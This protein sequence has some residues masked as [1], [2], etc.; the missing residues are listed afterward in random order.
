MRFSILINESISS[1]FSSSRGF[2]QGDPLSPLLFVIVMDALSRMMSTTVYNVLLSGFSIG[3]RNDEETIVL[4]LLI[5]DDT[6]IFCKPNCE[7]LCTCNV[8]S[9]FLISKIY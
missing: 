6:L 2:R 1:L 8:Y 3:A 9:F 4:H 5:I 7:Q